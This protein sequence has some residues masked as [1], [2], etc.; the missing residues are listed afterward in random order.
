[1]ESVAFE[2]LLI[3]QAI[4]G[5]FL[6]LTTNLN[7]I[8][9]WSVQPAERALGMSQGGISFPISVIHTINGEVIREYVLRLFD[10]G[11]YYLIV[12]KYSF[13]IPL[14]FFYCMRKV[15]SFVVDLIITVM[16]AASGAVQC[17]MM[18]IVH[19]GIVPM[20]KV[21]HLFF[22]CPHVQ[23]ECHVIN[24]ADKFRLGFRSILMQR[25]NMT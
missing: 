8:Q 5:L 2:I 12:S 22:Y 13:L 23:F 1:M 16:Q 20:H 9:F 3:V 11:S 14:Q 25:R 18:D 7:L 15:S 17:Q 19:P 24:G 4:A 21:T 6:V 10:L